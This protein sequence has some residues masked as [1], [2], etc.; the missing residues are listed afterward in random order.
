MMLQ[1]AICLLLPPCIYHVW[2]TDGDGRLLR[3][4]TEEH[5]ER[6]DTGT[7]QRN[8]VLF[9]LGQLLNLAWQNIKVIRFVVHSFTES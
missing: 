6:P 4:A 7:A 2:T 1:F 3:L 5:Y 8:Q 9:T